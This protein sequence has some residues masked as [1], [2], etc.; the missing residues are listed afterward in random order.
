[1]VKGDN[2]T[3]VGETLKPGE[4]AFSYVMLKPADTAAATTGKAKGGKNKKRC[5]PG[6]GKRLPPGNRWSHRILR[7][8]HQC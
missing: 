5:S 4:C 8:H 7:Y 1:M 6:R 3:G 2:N